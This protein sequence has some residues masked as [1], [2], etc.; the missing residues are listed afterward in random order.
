MAFLKL[1]RLIE[2]WQHSLSARIVVCLLFAGL[3]VICAQ[4]SGLT[5]GII[6]SVQFV[7]VRCFEISSLSLSGTILRP[8]LLFAISA[9]LGCRFSPVASLESRILS[10]SSR[11]FSVLEASANVGADIGFTNSSTSFSKLSLVVTLD[12]SSSSALYSPPDSVLAFLGALLCGR[13]EP[14]SPVGA[15]LF[16]LSLPGGHLSL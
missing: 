16:M 7:G 4:I 10:M 9:S 5:Q 8:H 1:S 15:A 11:N 13:G 6:I 2:G 12:E 3:F 14:E